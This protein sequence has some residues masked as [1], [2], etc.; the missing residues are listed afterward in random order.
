[1]IEYHD[2]EWGVPVHDDRTHF[3]FLILEGAQAG[4]S[5]STILNKR[6]G[7]RVAFAKFD[8]ERVARFTARDC[9][10]LL[11]HGD[12]VRNRLK[13]ASDRRQRARLS[14][15]PGGVRVVRRLCLAFRQWQADRASTEVRARCAGDDQGVRHIVE[16]SQVAGHAIRRQHDHVRLHAGRRP[17]ERSPAHLLSRVEGVRPFLGLLVRHQ[18]VH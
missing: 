5:W 15:D 17:R 16:G 9:A 13:I 18:P 1:M 14:R 3:E 4:L 6:A 12:I 8:P 2:T 7:Y 10:R 11:K